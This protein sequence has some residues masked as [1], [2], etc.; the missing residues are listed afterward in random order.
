MVRT[1]LLMR[2][3]K[4][5]WGDAGL[6]DH[7]RPLNARGE[8]A[9]PRMGRLL[10]ERSM[11][12]TR[13]LLST[14]VRARQTAELVAEAAGVGTENCVSLEDLYLA[15]PSVLLES[16]ARRGGDAEILLVVAH[17]PGIEELVAL[18]GRHPE[19]FPTAALAGFRLGI[20]EWAEAEL[21]MDAELVG[22]WRPRELENP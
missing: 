5:D 9:A 10:V 14:A 7:D 13:I 17:N 18:L 20:D 15:P 22:V 1:L 8:A 21:D 12:P 3:A 6:R 2:H 16:I 4:S 19:A 11:V